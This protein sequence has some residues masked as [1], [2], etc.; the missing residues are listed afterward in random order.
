[1]T[2]EY[3]VPVEGQI[4]MV[5]VS[6]DKEALLA[7]KAAG[8]ASVELW[9]NDGGP[10]LARYVVESPEDLSQEYLERVVRRHLGLPWEILRTERLV[11]RE[12]CLGD[13]TCVPEDPED[14]EADRTF[15]DRQRLR[16]YIQ[17]QYGFY[18]YG[19]WAVTERRSGVIVGK[20]GVTNAWWE[21][22]GG[23]DPGEALEL[24]YHIF[25]PY[26][27]RG[28]GRE[29]CQGILSWCRENSDFPYIYAKT[30]SQNQKS[31][32]LLEKLGFCLT[33]QRCSGSGQ[34]Q[35]LFRRNC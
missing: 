33:D 28:Y 27:E 4:H 21:S 19:I 16:E 30:D 5:V 22:E 1:M 26:R 20:A 12:F 14:G 6:D 9:K 29:A 17:C 10:F 24:G 31:A 23:Q 2:R 11:I 7:A 18:G 35:F 13:E 34:R 32:G 25:T 8:K 15:R 3:P